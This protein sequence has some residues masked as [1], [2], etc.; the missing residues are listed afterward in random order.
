MKRHSDK[1]IIP[2]IIV[3]LG[4]LSIVGT[5]L[6]LVRSRT[7]EVIKRER[8]PHIPE[9]LFSQVINASLP[10]V[11][12]LWEEGDRFFPNEGLRCDNEIIHHKYVGRSYYQCNPHF[13]QCY[14]QGGVKEYP[15]IEIDLFGKKYHVQAKASFDPIGSF[16]SSPRYY[17]L[18]KKK[19]FSLQIDYGYVV[20]LEVKELPGLSQS[21]ILTDSCRDTFLPE[22]I[23]GYGKVQDKRDEGFIW[24][25]FGRK[26]FIDR[27][28]VTNRMVN[29]W[30]IL[31]GESQKFEKDRTKWPR[32]AFL[33]FNE[34]K[35]YCEFYG[36]RLLE[37]KLFDAATMSPSDLK[38]SKPTRIY[39]PDTPWQRDITKS[40]LGTAR[41]NP[42]Y[43]LTPLDC[44]LAEVQGCNEKLFSTDS[45]TWM[46]IYFGLGFYPE[47]FQNFIE[48]K[49]NIK[50]SSHFFD[51]ASMWHE[52]G[53]LSSW[54]GEQTDSLPVAFRCY[55]EV[56][57]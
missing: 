24:D 41:I 38:D 46:G 40:F 26:I 49:K 30:R 25:N 54:N 20:E 55:E 12:R 9:K 29:E 3:F 52:L 53:S 45:A 13:W 28:Y 57:E 31:S 44:Q 18:Y 23:Y 22:R 43:Q 15:S 42:D 34:Q 48:P 47:S 14:W 35:S 17:G 8:L 16:S 56:S 10:S 5:I 27:F 37:A 50:M 1:S 6:L 7:P 4:T 36:K 19:N 33:S 32:P 2:K 51:P 11:L 21:I 39:R